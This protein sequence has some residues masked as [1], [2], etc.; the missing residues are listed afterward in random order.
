M[1]PCV[2]GPLKKRK[3]RK[4]DYGESSTILSDTTTAFPRTTA[5]LLPK[6]HQPDSHNEYI[7]FET[8]EVMNDE[9]IVVLRKMVLGKTEYKTSQT[10]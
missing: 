5:P 10:A 4:I 3:R 9:S 7:D 1:T 2:L 6:G 8:V